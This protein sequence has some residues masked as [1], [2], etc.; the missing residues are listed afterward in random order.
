MSNE[1]ISRR[2]RFHSGFF[3]NQRNRG[4]QHTCQKRRPN[5]PQPFCGESE[6]TYNKELLEKEEAG[7]EMNHD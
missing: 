2:R 4:G 3:R 1:G 7:K 5:V 6:N